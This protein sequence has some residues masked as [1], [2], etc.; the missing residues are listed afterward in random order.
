MK[1]K[2]LFFVVF[3]AALVLSGKFY[4]EGSPYLA[5]LLLLMA[6]ASALNLSRPEAKKATRFKDIVHLFTKQA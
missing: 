1:T 3:L 6:L 4:F 5:T 2:Y